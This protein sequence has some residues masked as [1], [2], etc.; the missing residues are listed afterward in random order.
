MSYL[1]VQNKMKKYE[2]YS[3]MELKQS[4]KLEIKTARSAGNLY[5]LK[6]KNL[7]KV[8]NGLKITGACTVL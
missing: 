7:R 4:L 3:E 5:H 1:L 8:K 2:F 6:I